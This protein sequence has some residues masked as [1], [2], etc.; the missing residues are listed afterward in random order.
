MAQA[1]SSRF[2]QINGGEETFLSGDRQVRIETRIFPLM[3]YK[4]EQFTGGISSNVFGIKPI[5]LVAIE[6]GV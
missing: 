4:R 3:L 1:A 2:E 6:Y 5:Q